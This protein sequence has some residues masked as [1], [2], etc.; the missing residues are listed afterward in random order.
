[1]LYLSIKVIIYNI[2]LAT[3]LNTSFKYIVILLK[4]ATVYKLV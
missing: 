4:A 2:E 1:M 3:L